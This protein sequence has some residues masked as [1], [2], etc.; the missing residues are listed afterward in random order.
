[1]AD[2]RRLHTL[3]APSS[4]LHPLLLAPC[5]QSLSYSW[6]S[7]GTRAELG[8]GWE[9]GSGPTPFIPH[10]GASPSLSGQ[11]RRWVSTRWVAEGT[12]GDR[13][14]HKNKR[15]QEGQGGQCDEEGKSQDLHGTQGLQPHT[16]GES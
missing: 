2:A 12:Q 7:R 3:A 16:Q 15:G 13:R 6:G 1:M 4:P 8:P 9:R 14:R 5:S 11:G 10:A